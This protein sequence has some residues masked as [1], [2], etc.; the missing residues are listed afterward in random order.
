MTLTRDLDAVS[1]WLSSVALEL[2]AS[3][4]E[5]RADDA[6]TTADAR[7]RVLRLSLVHSTEFVR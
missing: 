5:A 1:A 3:T 2:P 6:V 7:L 4:F